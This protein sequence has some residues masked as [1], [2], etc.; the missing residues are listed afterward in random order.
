FCG[1]TEQRAQA[2]VPIC[3]L[4]HAGL[5]GTNLGENLAAGHQDCAKT[6]QQWTDE[7]AK[8]ND[9]RSP[10][11]YMDT[12]HY[13]QVVWKSTSTLCCAVVSAPQCP[14]KYFTACNYYPPGNYKR[15]F[16]DNVPSS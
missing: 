4:S 3:S 14:Y 13:T 11:F 15:R 5:A 6:V 1:F 9:G 8:Y 7:A 2:Q 16:Q 12:G 10:G